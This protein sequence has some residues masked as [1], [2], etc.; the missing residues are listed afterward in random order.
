M[1]LPVDREDL[2]SDFRVRALGAPCTHDQYLRRPQAF[3]EKAHVEPLSG[4]AFGLSVITDDTTAAYN[5][6]STLKCNRNPL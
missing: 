1:P 6:N 5:V 2:P 3:L 4:G